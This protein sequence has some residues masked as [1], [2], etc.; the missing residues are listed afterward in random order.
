M[1]L[2]AYAYVFKLRS[3]YTM[4]RAWSWN[5]SIVDLAGNA[6]LYFEASLTGCLKCKQTNVP[7]LSCFT[8]I[9]WELVFSALDI[10]YVIAA[11]SQTMYEHELSNVR[12]IRYR[13]IWLPGA[14][15]LLKTQTHSPCSD[16]DIST[17][18]TQWTQTFRKSYLCLCLCNVCVLKLISTCH[19]LA[20]V[21]V[22]VKH[23]VSRYDVLQML[24]KVLA[25][26]CNE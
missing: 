15:Q 18:V 5:F 26:C 1:L 24:F 4:T 25:I 19:W 6:V 8:H 16:D 20:P 3:F 23:F 17:P 22:L 2:K 21:Y 10:W 11:W 9:L 13:P 7:H 14:W 12:L